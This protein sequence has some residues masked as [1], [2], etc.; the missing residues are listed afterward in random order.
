[1]TTTETGVKPIPAYAPPVDEKWMKLRR[2]A[3]NRQKRLAQK[4]HEA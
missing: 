1:M 4:T 2:A 3:L